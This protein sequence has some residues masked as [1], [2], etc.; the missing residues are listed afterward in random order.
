MI[1][2]ERLIKRL[3]DKLEDIGLRCADIG[4][5]V[6]FFKGKVAGLPRIASVPIFDLLEDEYVRQQLHFIGLEREEIETFIA[7]NR[8][9]G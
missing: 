5:R 9:G 2:R 4:A 8:Q 7:Q 1:R 6:A 3:I